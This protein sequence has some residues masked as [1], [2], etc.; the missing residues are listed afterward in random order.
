MDVRDHLV[1]FDETVHLQ[2][3]TIWLA[4]ELVS[5]VTGSDRNRQCVNAGLLDELS[6]L[7]R[8]RDMLEAGSASAMSVFDSAQYTDLAFDGD[9]LRVRHLND[10][11]RGIY[12]VLEAR[13][14]LSVRHQRA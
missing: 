10:L 8:I 4:R 11:P 7:F 13:R 9:T 6:C 3:C 2:N 5:A 12:V 14:S 1:D